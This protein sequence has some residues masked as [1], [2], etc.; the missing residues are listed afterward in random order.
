MELLAERMLIALMLNGLVNWIPSPDLI[1]VLASLRLRGFAFPEHTDIDHAGAV[2]DDE[3]RGG[4]DFVVVAATEVAPT[5]VK[6]SSASA[7]ETS[8]STRA[9]A[10]IALFISL[11]L[12]RSWRYTGKDR[13]TVTIPTQLLGCGVPL[14]ERSRFDQDV[15]APRWESESETSFGFGFHVAT[16]WGH[17]GKQSQWSMLRACSDEQTVFVQM[18]V[19]RCAQ[20]A[21]RLIGPLQKSAPSLV[22]QPSWD[23]TFGAA[24][25]HASP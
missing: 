6:P 12:L 18:L 1:S 23:S 7:T 13:N 20:L 9:S 15:D 4:V 16:R 17:L 11:L 21:P 14:H 2:V 3:Q 22:A 19:S 25:I 24:V 8:A 10:R 5:R